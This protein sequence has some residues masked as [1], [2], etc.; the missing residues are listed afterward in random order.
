M[1]EFFADYGGL[2]APVAAIV[3]GFI[4]ILVAQ[5]FKD[6]TKAKVILVVSAAILGVAAIGASILNQRQVLAIKIAEQERSKQNREALGSFIG[7]GLALIAD[8]SDK[9]TPP[10]WPELNDWVNRVKTFLSQNMGDSYAVRIMRL[11]VPL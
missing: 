3:N 8:C 7:E 6:N 11:P 2:I 1:K 10:K 4:A 5:F 9:S